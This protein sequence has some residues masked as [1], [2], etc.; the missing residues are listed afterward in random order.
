M[1]AVT[2]I[3]EEIKNDNKE[4]SVLRENAKITIKIAPEDF[5][6][7]FVLLAQKEMLKRGL[8]RDFIIDDENKEIINQLF[9]YLTNSEKFN[10]CQH[11]GILLAGSIGAGKTLIMN[12]ICEIIELFSTKRITKIHSKRVADVL[13]EH[14][15]GWLDKRPL[16]ID[17]LG[18]E[19]KEVNNYGTKELPIIDLISIRYDF[20]ALTFATTNF[21]SEKLA[22]FYGVAIVDRFKEMFNMLVL[23]GASKRV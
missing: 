12:V 20:G 23:K 11:K 17:D 6:E 3:I 9:F 8:K 15:K 14:D 21:D 19:P 10:G 22:E 1:I 7:V 13:K 2:K 18:R 4:L 5:K 16:F